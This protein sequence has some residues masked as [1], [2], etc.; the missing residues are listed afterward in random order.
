[1]KDLRGKRCRRAN[2]VQ[3]V[4]RLRSA[5]VGMKVAHGRFCAW[6]GRRRLVRKRNENQENYLLLLSFIATTDSIL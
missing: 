6:P 5:R 3:C 4:G 2:E 1:M